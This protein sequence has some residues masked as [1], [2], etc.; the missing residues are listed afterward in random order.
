MASAIFSAKGLC[1]STANKMC[2]NCDVDNM[3]ISYR[4]RLPVRNSR[5]VKQFDYLHN[6]YIT[7]CMTTLCEVLFDLSYNI[8]DQLTVTMKLLFG[9]FTNAITES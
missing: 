7:F 3:V 5:D 4:S 1:K 6:T 2:L 8:N 9:H